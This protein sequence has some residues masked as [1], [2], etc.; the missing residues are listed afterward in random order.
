MPSKPFFAV[1]VRVPASSANLG[2]GFDALGLALTLYDVWT[3][4]GGDFD[5]PL[6]IECENAR[7]VP[8]DRS[9]LA[10]R[11]FRRV[12]ELRRRSLPALRFELKSALPVAGGLGSSSAAIVGGLVAANAVLGRPFST[13]ALLDLAA[14]FEGHPDNVAPAL[15]GGFCSAVIVGKKARCVAWNGASLFRGLAAVTATPDFALK[16]EKARAVLPARVTRADAVFNVGRAALMASALLSRRH[17]LL[18][19]AMDD[20]LHQPYRRPLIPGFAGALAA[21]VKAGAHG[22]A[23]SGAGPT[24]LA[25]APTGRAVAAARAMERAFARAGVRAASNVLSI[26][27][28]GAV[29]TSLRKA[30]SV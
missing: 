14:E 25:L 1:T 22:A 17:E 2:P 7:G 28:R 6:A 9:N 8:T 23:L 27:T 24:V 15:L 11:A 29:V 21:A 16:T 12:F 5:A 3:V 19:V 10:Y 4:R 18:S 20:R 30:S 13:D 26:D